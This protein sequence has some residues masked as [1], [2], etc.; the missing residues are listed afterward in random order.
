MSVTVIKSRNVD[1]GHWT[2]NASSVRTL[3]KTDFC[4]NIPP[5]V[6]LDGLTSLLL[7]ALFH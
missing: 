6:I 1:I 4:M 3:P 2:H 7:G 5:F